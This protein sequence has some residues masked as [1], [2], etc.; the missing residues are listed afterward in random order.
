MFDNDEYEITLFTEKAEKCD[1]DC[2][3]CGSKNIKKDG[4]D[5]E[6]V[7]AGGYVA[8]CVAEPK[9]CLKCLYKWYAF[10]NCS[11]KQVFGYRSR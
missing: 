8:G 7:D 6:C 4:K 2:P 1:T 10:R 5:S 9:K 3:K 11:T